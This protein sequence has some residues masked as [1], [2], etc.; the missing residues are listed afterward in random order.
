MKLLAKIL[1][2]DTLYAIVTYSMLPVLLGG[3]ILGF[4]LGSIGWLVLLIVAIFMIAPLAFRRG[5]DWRAL[6]RLQEATPYYERGR[7]YSYK[8]AYDRAIAEYSTA[9]GIDRDNPASYITRGHAYMMKREDELAM[10]DFDTAINVAPKLRGIAYRSLT[11]RDAWKD[12]LVN[13]Y[14]SRGMAYYYN[15]EYDAAI[16]DFDAAIR[17]DS[18]KVAH[19]NLRGGGMYYNDRGRAYLAKEE[20][21]LA[22]ADF[23]A[24]I[25]WGSYNSRPKAEYY[26][27]RGLAC[28][29]KGEY[30]QAIDDFNTVISIDPDGRFTSEAYD[31]RGN[32]YEAK[33][34]YE[35]A[36]ADFNAT[37]IIRSDPEDEEAD[38]ETTV[39]YDNARY[40]H[41]KGQLDLAIAEYDAALAID[42]S[43]EAAYNNR[44]L[45]YLDKGEYDLAIADFNAAM[46]ISSDSDMLWWVAYD[47]RCKA[48]DGLLAKFDAAI[49]VDPRDLEALISR[50]AV[51]LALGEHD[52]AIADLD[53]VVGIDPVSTRA[54]SC[55]GHT[56][57]AKAEHDLAIADFDA[58]IEIDSGD[59]EVYNG[60]GQAYRAKEEYDLA[61]A[62]YTAA[63]SIDPNFA[64]AYHNR[65]FAYLAKSEYD[66]AIA[67]H[68]SAIAIDSDYAEEEDYFRLGTPY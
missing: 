19:P 48:Y 20:H 13:A 12:D 34:E 63:I 66:L 39:H 60:R 28:L 64:G 35:S 2:S 42:P 43:E 37:R 44:G 26:N 4:W 40:Y 36:A 18:R 16:T 10:A 6:R 58:S 55:R 29:A 67:D 57:I 24:A 9:I 59:S 22:I 5:L 38:D 54:Y 25:R 50:G 51:Y 1:N 31:S 7:A 33:G 61:I 49:A 52:L 56:Y 65:S 15:E 32:A 53:T 68:Y 11:S 14:H 27:N 21:D 17:L 45:A 3:L 8:Q 41:E 46:N 23:N 30:D 62:D 47:N